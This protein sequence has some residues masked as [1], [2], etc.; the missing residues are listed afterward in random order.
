MLPTIRRT[1]PFDVLREFDRA[2]GRWPAWREAEMETAYYPVDIH[3]DNENLY[4]EAELPGFKREEINVNIE[5]GVL[6]INAQRKAEEAKSGQHLKERTYT[7]ISRRFSLPTTVNTDKVQARLGNG[8][9]S[10]QMPKREEVKPR[11]I[12]VK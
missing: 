8:V 1:D 4:V 11:K 9:L 10:L 2:F 7:R 5:Q 12:E 6:T 3:E